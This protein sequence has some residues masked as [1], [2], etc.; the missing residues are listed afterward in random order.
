MKI[1]RS[2][3]TKF[4]GDHWTINKDIV[5]TYIPQAGDVALFEIIDL[6]KHTSIQGINGNNVYLFP[7][8]QMLAAFGNRY[9]TAQFEGY[10]PNSYLDEYHILG[11]GGVVGDIASMHDKFE[12]IGTTTLKIIGYAID[13]KGKVLNS[14][15]HHVQPIT[16]NILKNKSFDIILSVGTSM[17]SGKTTS[18]GFLC[19]GLS[20]AGKKTAYIKLTGTAYTKDKSFVRDCGAHIVK[21]FSDAGFPSTYV[22]SIDELMH[23]HWTLIDMVATSNPDVIVI[24]L[25]DGIIQRETK[26]LLHY[27]PFMDSVDGILLSCGDSLSVPSCVDLLSKIEMPPFAIS[28]ILTMSPL[29]IQEVEDHVNIDVLTIEQLCEPALISEYV[30]FKK[31]YR[32]TL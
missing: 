16:Q 6:G 29:M 5:H 23:L 22:C 3:T 10:V 24:E 30:N 12:D 8:D 27:A 13:E 14:K 19:R 17:D 1:K 18:A 2:I 15:F 20:L 28:G 21:D 7:G 25:A 31:R 26:A 9:A 4:L 32:A 11:K